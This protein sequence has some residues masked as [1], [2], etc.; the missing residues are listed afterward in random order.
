MSQYN[1]PS[2]PGI[3]KWW[4]IGFFIAAVVFFIIGGA[5]VGTYFSSGYSTC[6]TYSSF[7]SYYYDYSC[8]DGNDGEFYG[9]IAMI[10]IGGVCKLVAWILLI[11]FCVQRRRFNQTNI[12]YV[13]APM[14]A[15]QP[16]AQQGYVAPQPTYPPVDP[17]AQFPRSPASPAPYPASVSTPPPKEATA[18]AFRYCGQCGTAMS[19]RFCPQCGFGQ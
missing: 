16:V 7:S 10:V 12:T 3:S 14:A 6:S 13:N 5:L 17:T 18:T 4:C 15:P 8:F 11:V 19:S 2:R 1:T 9:G